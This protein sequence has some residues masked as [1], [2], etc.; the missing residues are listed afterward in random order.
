[1][2]STETPNER[3]AIKTWTS[4][5]FKAMRNHLNLR[6]HAIR[7]QLQCEVECLNS[8]LKFECAANQRPHVDFSRTHQC[9]GSRIKVRIPNT[10]SIDASF[11]LSAT[12]SN[13]TALI[14]ME[15][16]GKLGQGT[17]RPETR[18]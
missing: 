1:M 12:K 17:V 14:G 7:R 11:A 16:P 9:Q 10:V 5:P 3:R 2:K 8:I 6:F 13:E 15:W 4:S 18:K